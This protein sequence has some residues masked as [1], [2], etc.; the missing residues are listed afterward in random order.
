MAMP[1]V[2]LP[3]G[4]NSF[5]LD[6]SG[7]QG[8]REYLNPEITARSGAEE[9]FAAAY[10]KGP[11]MVSL[12]LGYRS[13]PFLE[14]EEFFHSPNVCLPSQGWQTIEEATMVIPEVHPNFDPFVVR[15]MLLA[16]QGAHLLVFYWFQTRNTIAHDIFRNRFHLALHALKRDNTSDT[17]VRLVTLVPRDGS[18]DEAQAWMV[19]FVHN[20]EPV[21][22]QFLGH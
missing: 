3:Q 8:T 20:L 9:A 14:S 10:R 5:P 6:F 21:L 19:T 16:Q 1:A 7:W 13:S 11:A 18:L 4:I 2:R 15:R 12:Y 17:F 22:L